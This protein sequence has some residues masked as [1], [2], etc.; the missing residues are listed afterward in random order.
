MFKNYDLKI[1]KLL[2][3]ARLFIK[4]DV[5]GVGFRMWT[6][7]QAEIIGIKGWVRNKEDQVEAVVQGEEEKI[8]KIIGLIKQGPPVSHVDNVEISW[9]NPIEVFETF[10]IRT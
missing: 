8:N 3:Q 1:K 9:E 2:K 4:G 5:I 6:K 7:M 10:K